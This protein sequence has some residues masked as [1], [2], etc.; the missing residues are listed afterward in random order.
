MSSSPR[1]GDSEDR[2]YTPPLPPS[3]CA[4][5]ASLPHSSPQPS[6]CAPTQPVD[7]GACFLTTVK[8]DGS[9]DSDVYQSSALEAQCNNQGNDKNSGTMTNHTQLEKPFTASKESSSDCRDPDSVNIVSVDETSVPVANKAVATGN[10]ISVEDSNNVITLCKKS[11]DKFIQYPGKLVTSSAPVGNGV[12]SSEDARVSPQNGTDIA[13]GHQHWSYSSN[14]SRLNGDTERQLESSLS[15]SNFLPGIA[16]KVQE[17]SDDPRCVQASEVMADSPASPLPL[18]GDGTADPSFKGFSPVE[19][20]SGPTNSLVDLKMLSNSCNV[21]EHHKSYS[22]P[23]ELSSAAAPEDYSDSPASPPAF[24]ASL[25]TLSEQEG[26]NHCPG[27]PATPPP[28]AQPQQCSTDNNNQFCTRGSSSVD[29]AYRSRS[30]CTPPL[31]S[32]LPPPLPPPPLTPPPPPLSPPPPPLSPPPSSGSSPNQ[33]SPSPLSVKENEDK[34]KQHDSR[35]PSDEPQNYHGCQSPIINSTFESNLDDKMASLMSKFTGKNQNGPSTTDP[36]INL[37]KSKEDCSESLSVSSPQSPDRP[38]LPPVFTSFLPSSGEMFSGRLGG[39]L[40]NTSPPSTSSTSSSGTSDTEGSLSYGRGSSLLKTPRDGNRA[41]KK[42]SV[43]KRTSKRTTPSPLLD[44]NIECPPSPTPQ[45]GSPDSSRSPSP[46]PLARASEKRKSVDTG[47]SMQRKWRRNVGG[48]HDMTDSRSAA[49]VPPI[50]DRPSTGSHLSVRLQPSLLP[51][52]I[53]TSIPPPLPPN[54]PPP[55]IPPPPPHSLARTQSPLPVLP[56]SH[57]STGGPFLPLRGVDIL[58]PTGSCRSDIMSPT[59]GCDLMSPNTPREVLGGPTSTTR[60]LD[61]MSP[62]TPGRGDIMS[63]PPQSPRYCSVM[64]PNH[65]SS[66]YFHS[67]SASCKVTPTPHAAAHNVGEGGKYSGGT[68]SSHSSSHHHHHH[69]HRSS[70]SSNSGSSRRARSPMD[71]PVPK[72]NIDPIYTRPRVQ[73]KAPIYQKERSGKTPP[74]QRE[75]SFHK[76]KDIIIQPVEPRRITIPPSAEKLRRYSEDKERIFDRDKRLS[77]ESIDSPRSRTFD[78]N[79]NSGNSRA[80]ERS[81]SVSSQSSVSKVESETESV[82]VETDTETETKPKPTQQAQTENGGDVKLDF[83]D[84]VLGELG[85]FAAV[86][87]TSIYIGPEMETVKN[88]TPPMNRIKEEEMNLLSSTKS[89]SKLPTSSKKPD[90]DISTASSNISLNLSFDKDDSV[91]EPEKDTVRV[92]CIDTD[93]RS[94]LKIEQVEGPPSEPCAQVI[95]VETNIEVPDEIKPVN[96]VNSEIK[97]ESKD[98]K[99]EETKD[100][101]PEKPSHKSDKLDKS[102]RQ[103]KSKS[104]SSSHDSAR[105]HHRD[106]SST[107]SSRNCSRCYKRSK[108]KRYNCGV[109]CDLIKNGGFI[110]AGRSSS[111]SASQAEVKRPNLPRPKTLRSGLK[112]GHL[113][114][115]ETYPNGE[116]SVCHMYEDEMKHL[117]PQEKEE[118]AREFLEGRHRHGPPPRLLH[119]EPNNFAHHVKFLEIT[120]D[121]KL[122]WKPYSAALKIVV[123]M[124]DSTGFAE[125]VC[126]IVHDSAHYM[127]DLLDYL[128]DHHA[129]LIVKAGVIGHIGRNSDLETYTMQKYKEEVYRAYCGGTFRAG[130]LHQV[131]VVGTVHEEVGG[132]FPHF[133]S[134]VEENPFLRLAMPWGELSSL[135][136]SPPQQSNDGPIVWIRPGEQL[137][138]TAELGKSPAKRK[139]TGINELQ[140]LQYLPRATNAREMMFEDRTKAHADHVGA[141]LYRRTTGAVGIL[142]AV[143]CGESYTH[144]RVVKDV[145][146][147]DAHDF[148]EVAEKLQLDLH[149]PPT[150][151]CIVWIEDAK[152]NQLRREGIRFA[153]IQLCD[154][155]IYFLPRNIIHQFRTVTAVCSVAWH[156]QLK[157]YSDSS[158]G[159]EAIVGTEEGKENQISYSLVKNSGPDAGAAVDKQQLDGDA[160]NADQGAKKRE[161]KSGR[162]EDAPPKEPKKDDSKKLSQKHERRKE[163]SSSGSRDERRDKHKHHKHKRDKDKDRPKDN[164]KSDKHSKKRDRRDSFDDVEKVKKKL[165]LGDDCPSSDARLCV[166]QRPSGD[167]RSSSSSG[168]SKGSVAPSSGEPAVPVPEAYRSDAASSEGCVEKTAGSTQATP[169]TGGVDATSTTTTSSGNDTTH[170]A[171]AAAAAPSSSGSSPPGTSMGGS[172]SNPTCSNQSSTPK[173]PSKVRKSSHSRTASTSSVDLLDSIMATMTSRPHK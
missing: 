173:V 103:E 147:F 154:N 111:D 153:R 27:S 100:V 84:E 18:T 26:Q 155:D 158:K 1:D 24:T 72:W 31:P 4:P 90:K 145:V 106:S 25:S 117:T 48:T 23:S 47:D 92:A 160:A 150:S 161:T 168:G 107:N 13:V 156:V 62:M 53:N 38:F 22:R 114:H 71:L 89:R 54:I 16:C 128:G 157:Q 79:S 130:P 166:D 134:M 78:E 121:D 139:R 3:N 115:I 144:N 42:R 76:D 116:A 132:Y 45:F 143:H 125:H 135:F 101:K 30:P 109:Q 55:P 51:L 12:S 88:K 151:Q 95:K 63:P 60:P 50:P 77:V 162:A 5:A 34:V 75:S 11:N 122:S 56:S 9:P 141:G 163:E 36:L 167:A 21:D 120:L 87:D 43:R 46:A 99:V 112:Y 146:A 113:I 152:L 44:A 35:F 108:M 14:C 94:T 32:T 133:L 58:S 142:K 2:S 57:E 19:H 164:E 119:G 140:R 83:Q 137:I 102:S 136:G 93:V 37:S 105:R 20:S 171:A 169:T 170:T 172:T 124:E 7:D 123:F 131:S 85:E 49:S 127:P 69:H 96:K 82:A 68:H 70:R 15:S 86:G 74:Y 59:R 6:P 110:D 28:L 165:K 73:T 39:G 80:V 10:E 138:P 17:R 52:C 33:A 126:G 41:K 118:A 61:V 40:A 81:N 91:S 104:T 65:S 159:E 29:Q 66:A 64:S 98:E 148:H 149:E 67:L 8:P 129:S 97:L